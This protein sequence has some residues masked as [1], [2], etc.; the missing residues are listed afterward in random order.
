M[1]VIAKQRAEELAAEAHAAYNQRVLENLKSFNG[2]RE[3]P[4]AI[5]WD[6]LVSQT[7][8]VSS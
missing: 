1:A 6:E 8:S 5:H 4:N 7:H 3:D 2:V